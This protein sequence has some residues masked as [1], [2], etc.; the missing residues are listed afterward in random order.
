VLIVVASC[1]G[2]GLVFIAVLA[3]LLMPNFARAR[4]AARKASCRSNAKIMGTAMMMYL[5]D[6]D[7]TFPPAA[8]W[9]E[10]VLPYHKTPHTLDCPSRPTVTPGYAFNRQLAEKSLAKVM[11][12]EAAPMLFE[13]SLGTPSASDRLESFATPHA[14]TGNVA[15]SNGAVQGVSQAPAA[16]AGLSTE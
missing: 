14:G 8:N 11:E 4:D 9:Q 1:A 12:P 3:A 13:S 10:G 6:Y 15:F 7:E 2:V 5:Q 16:T